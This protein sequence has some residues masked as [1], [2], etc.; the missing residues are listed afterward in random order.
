MEVLETNVVEVYGVG[1]NLREMAADTENDRK[2]VKPNL[3]VH[4]TAKE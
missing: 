4:N 1:N 3:K 2:L